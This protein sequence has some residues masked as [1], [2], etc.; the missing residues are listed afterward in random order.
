MNNKKI[1]VVWL[2]HFSNCEVHKRLDLHHG[3][4]LGVLK[5]MTRRKVSTDVPEFAIWVTNGIK[6]FEK[7]E[8]VEL[9]IVSP[10]PNLNS[11]IQEYTMNGIYYHFFKNEDDDAF[12]QVYRRVF[13]PH[14]WKYSE[15]R[16]RI[17]YLIKKIRPDVVHLIGAENPDYSLGLLDVLH[18]IV[19]IAQLQT[20]LID[21]DVKNHNPHF[22]LYQYRT[23]V[24]RKVIERAD[25]IGTTASKFRT[26]ILESIKP[27]ALFLNTGLA[28]TENVVK[29][30]E[31]KE[32][33]FVYFAAGLSK[34]ADLALEAFGMVFKEKPNVTL[35]VI[36]GCDA[37]FKRQ[38]ESI[39]EKYDMEDA[40]YFEGRLPTH[41]DVLRQIRKSKYALLPLRSD[42]VSGTIREAMSNGL[43]VLTTDTGELGTQ[44]LNASSQCALIS[45][46]GNHQALA[47]NMLRLLDDSELADTLRKNSYQKRATVRSN[48][49]TA[50]IYVEAYKACL[51]N[52]KNAIPIPERLTKVK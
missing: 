41:D 36:G 25:F 19:T 16:K 1:R 24:E 47:D 27:D 50:C 9:H 31:K 26:I 32:F 30:E 5:R 4:L 39:V 44:T 3:W 43:P 48:K 21:P 18:D 33:D 17:A 51:N 13:K 6:E 8:E 10:Y 52:K 23:D 22:P 46:I 2:C 28:L 14:F 42:L 49:E 38:L 34:A 7:F 29:G 40:V 12:K 20:L 35:D 11:N 37:S 15:N 45:E